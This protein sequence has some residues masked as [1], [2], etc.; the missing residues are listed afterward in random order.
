M[1]KGNSLLIKKK[2]QRSFL[3]KGS[4]IM[5]DDKNE[6]RNIRMTISPSSNY[7]IQKMRI[8]PK[9]FHY[10]TP[11]KRM[12]KV[13]MPYFLTSFEGDQPMRI[14]EN[15]ILQINSKAQPSSESNKSPT[16]PLNEDTMYIL[17]GIYK[18]YRNLI[19]C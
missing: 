4:G 1:N 13:I 10:K 15:P 6:L 11:E 8:L 7:T 2:Y 12:Q 14:Y 9:N 16:N 5:F 19:I 17:K 18:E 3:K